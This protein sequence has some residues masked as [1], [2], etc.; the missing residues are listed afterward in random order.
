VPQ[1]PFHLPADPLCP[2]CGQQRLIAR[3]QP[4]PTLGG[5]YERCTFECAHCD[6]PVKTAFGPE[7]DAEIEALAERMSGVPPLRK[8]G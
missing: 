3:R 4:H 6:R 2:K 7:T 1:K 8:H 5:D